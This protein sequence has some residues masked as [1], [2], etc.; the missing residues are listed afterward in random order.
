MLYQI[1][2]IVIT[3][4]CSFIII[5]F[6]TKVG[7]WLSKIIQLSDSKLVD[8]TFDPTLTKFKLKNWST[9]QKVSL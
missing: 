8:N 7:R 9:P 5:L 3:K 1:V 2:I 4:I 6:A